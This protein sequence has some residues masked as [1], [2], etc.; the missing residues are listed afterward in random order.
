M[1]A[2]HPDHLNDPATGHLERLELCM[3]NCLEMRSETIVR[4]VHHPGQGRSQCI[5]PA[6]L[7][8]RL[9][10]GLPQETTAVEP[11]RASFRNK[12]A[13]P[14][15]GQQLVQPRRCRGAG[16]K[17]LQLQSSVAYAIACT[18]AG[19]KIQGRRR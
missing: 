17:S 2:K 9:K 16:G 10:F 3:V 19:A 1:A 14:S 13:D 4:V 12:A 15:D 7:R 11:H 6:E 18:E 8:A 5:L